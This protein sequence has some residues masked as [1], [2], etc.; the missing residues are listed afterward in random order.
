MIFFNFFF[1]SDRNGPKVSD[2]YDPLSPAG[3]EFLKKILNDCEIA[4]TPV[5]LCGEMAGNPLDA[6]A[7][8]G[9]GFR[10]FGS[11]SQHKRIHIRFHPTAKHKKLG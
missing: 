6:M 2:R 4:S 1:A 3:L 11:K 8:I 10:S 9:I 7:L 5:S